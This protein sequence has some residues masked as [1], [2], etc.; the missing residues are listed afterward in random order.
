MRIIDA[1]GN[2]PGAARAFG[3][4][5]ASILS[6]IPF[7]LGYLWAAWHPEKRTWHDSLAGTWVIKPRA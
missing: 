4:M 5:V 7:G 1:A 6:G 3:R 2:P